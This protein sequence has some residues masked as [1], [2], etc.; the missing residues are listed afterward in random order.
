[1]KTKIT[2]L[3]ISVALLLTACGQV[4]SS[5]TETPLSLSPAV[6]EE[7]RQPQ[8]TPEP[9]TTG[10]SPAAA[11]TSVQELS[12]EDELQ[13]EATPQVTQIPIRRK[14]S[15][16]PPIPLNRLRNHQRKFPPRPSTP[17]RDMW[18]RNQRQNLNHP[19]R[20][21]YLRTVKPPSTPPTPMRSRNTMLPQTQV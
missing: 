7:T 13:P 19:P 15:R 12:Q 20:H 14:T 17:R 4:Q 1:M 9:T 10:Q 8:P 2:L 5:P 16:K 3:T 6:Q 21:R 11:S 18:S